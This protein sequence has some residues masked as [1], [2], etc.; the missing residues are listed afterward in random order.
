MEDAP[1][2]L[3]YPRRNHRSIEGVKYEIS[4][5]SIIASNT[6]KKIK[7][8]GTQIEIKLREELLRQRINFTSVDFVIASL[9]GNPDFVIPECKAVVFCDGDF[10]HGK[11]PEKTQTKSNREFWKA[12]IQSNISRD[13]RVNHELKAM[14]WKVFRFWESEIN[15]DVESCV[16]QIKDY[17]NETE[18][19]NSNA[20]TFTFIDLFAGIGGFR[21]PIEQLG[22][23]CL[24][25]SEIDKDS[26]KVYK[27]N[28][29]YGLDDEYEMGDI[30]KIFD[31]INETV[32]LVVGGVPCQSWSVAGK[33]RGFD[34]P[35][36]K[37]WEDSIRLVEIHQPKAFIFENVKGLYDPRNRLNLELIVES[38]DTI[39]Y[40]LVDPK[41]LNS[42][43]FGLPQNRDRIF[44]VGFRKDVVLNEEF[45]Y[46]E[47]LGVTPKLGDILDNVDNSQIRKKKFELEELY[48]GK[49]PMSRNRFQKLDELND[50]FVFSDIRD[51]HTTIHSWDLI[52]TNKRDREICMLFLKNRRKKE[53]GPK[54]GNPLSFDQLKKLD[55]KIKEHE[56]S[57]LI[58]KGIIREV[59]DKF[60]FVHSKNSSGI[61]GVYR[62]F[63]PNSDIFSTL[64]ATG[65]RDM[66]ATK[67]ITAETVEEY[68]S[69]FIREVYKK[70]KVRPISSKEA[71][72]LQGFPDNFVIH[73]NEKI[74][75]KQFGNA[76]STKVIYHLVRS[77]INTGVFE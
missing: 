22:G 71:G 74:A 62:V 63:L 58:D 20:Y 48:N 34:D 40:N 29:S 53:F 51:G 47:P 9:P 15:E 68:K 42:Y 45:N 26:I 12:K 57:R 23:K 7:S 8:S 21:I 39:G 52:R 46:P 44:I 73:E 61:K 67:N 24:G 72:R 30:T 49:V 37:L 17:I 27:K 43:D 6:M 56:L 60:E 14:G 13:K 5:P 28:F 76:V 19:N 35:R 33:M 2:N 65:T 66:V 18:V 55:P 25:F 59:D 75:K 11:E 77:V 32:D 64:T 36:G 54:D 69:K 3:K 16:T 4:K 50:F 1:S 41:L 70:G 10:W 38:L 31:P